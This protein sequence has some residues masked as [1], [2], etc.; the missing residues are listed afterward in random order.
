MQVRIFQAGGH[1]E[2]NDL[3]DTINSWL[4]QT[5]AKVQH[6]STAMCQIGD[7]QHGERYQHLTVTIL[8]QPINSN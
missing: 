6:V 7:A 4:N 5:G 3:E 2:I 1:S 8:Y